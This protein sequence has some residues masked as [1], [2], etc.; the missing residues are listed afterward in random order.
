MFSFFS[1]CF[2]IE[3]TVEANLVKLFILEMGSGGGGILN[4]SQNVTQLTHI[5]ELLAAGTDG[6][7]IMNAVLVT[8]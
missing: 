3:S 8:A 1:Y 4:R 6:G 5:F 2:G 7:K